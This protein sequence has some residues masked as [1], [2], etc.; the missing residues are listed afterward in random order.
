MT[1]IANNDEH[2]P[3]ADGVIEL[4]TQIPRA[5]PAGDQIRC[6]WQFTNNGE[7]TVA[8]SF[9][10]RTT[11]AR[12][13]ALTCSNGRAQ[14]GHYH[15]SAVLQ[16]PGGQ[17]TTIAA[18]LEPRTASDYQLRVAVVTRYEVLERTDIIRVEPHSPSDHPRAERSTTSLRP[19]SGAAPGTVTHSVQ[20]K[21]KRDLVCDRCECVRDGVGLAHRSPGR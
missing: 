1:A 16:I 17:T 15:G 4:S 12:L 8:A 13:A 7:T 2:Q 9:Y 19:Q 21:T 20:G 14:C 18:L 10:L 3:S 5:A 6:V 11:P